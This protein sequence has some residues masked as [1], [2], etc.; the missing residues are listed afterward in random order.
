MPIG[1]FDTITIRTTRNITYL[2]SNDSNIT[3][4]G[5]WRVAAIIDGQLLC[6]KESTV[7]RIP[8]SDVTLVHKVDLI[9]Q[10]R[11]MTDDL[12]KRRRAR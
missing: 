12:S 6:T 4:H 3:P 9:E 5:S 1:Q 2:S 7:I 8:S 11:N 10:L